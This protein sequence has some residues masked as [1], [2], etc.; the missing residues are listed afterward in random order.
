ML[1]GGIDRLIQPC[2][3]HPRALMDLLLSLLPGEPKRIG[4]FACYRTCLAESVSKARLQQHGGAWGA[5]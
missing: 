1:E 4:G 3:S 2:A 5:F